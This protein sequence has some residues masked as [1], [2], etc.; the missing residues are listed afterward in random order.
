MNPAQPYNFG[1]GHFSKETEELYHQFQKLF[2]ISEPAAMLIALRAASDAG[3][4]KKQYWGQVTIRDLAVKEPTSTYA[5]AVVKACVKVEDSSEKGVE[6][7]LQF[8]LPSLLGKWVA[9]IDAA[10][11]L[12]DGG[13]KARKKAA[14]IVVKCPGCNE[15]KFEGQIVHREKCPTTTWE[16]LEKNQPSQKQQEQ[17]KVK[18]AIASAKLSAKL[19]PPISALPPK[20][21]K[22]HHHSNW[23]PIIPGG[24]ME[25][26]R[27][28]H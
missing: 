7:E 22:P 26:N 14:A 16:A 20:K 18:A 11:G 23:P 4:L 12:D 24:G 15:W 8:P 17:L 27:R 21:S 10:F 2:G 13:T 9:T 1:K 5:M 28:K 25:T 19:G 3:H 6:P